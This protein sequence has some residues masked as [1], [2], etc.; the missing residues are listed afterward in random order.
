MQHKN[1]SQLSKKELHKKLKKQKS[2][3]LIHGIVVLLLFIIAAL[4]TYKKGI[5]FNSFLPFF[6]LPMQF[7]FFK[8][9]KILKKEISSKK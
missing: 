9:I 8:E 6:F 2:M 4:N 5:S 1:V 7:I 3:A